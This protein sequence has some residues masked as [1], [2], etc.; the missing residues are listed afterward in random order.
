MLVGLHCCGDLSSVLCHLAE[1]NEEIVGLVLV[2]CCYHHL[3]EKSEL[4]K[5]SSIDRYSTGIA[6]G[7]EKDGIASSKIEKKQICDEFIG[8]PM[9]NMLKKEKLVLGQNARMLACHSEDRIQSESSLK[10][11]FFRALLKTFLVEYFPSYAVDE[12]GKD[13]KVGKIFAKVWK[14]KDLKEKEL[15][16]DYVKLAAKKLKIGEIKEDILGTGQ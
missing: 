2:P 16:R 12:S 14:K 3:S 11:V 4:D 9:S 13:V 6:R 7:L 15:F 10:S 8:F 1:I 5:N